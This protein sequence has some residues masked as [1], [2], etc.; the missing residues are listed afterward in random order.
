M[1]DN[2]AW[3]A[4]IL[5]AIT[6]IVASIVIY[7]IIAIISKRTKDQWIKYILGILITFVVFNAGWSLITNFYRTSDGNLIDAIR[8]LSLIFSATSG[9]VSIIGWY[10]LLRKDE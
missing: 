9:L 5:R 7:R 6:L 1:I 10:V 8:H 3:I 2:Y 4:I